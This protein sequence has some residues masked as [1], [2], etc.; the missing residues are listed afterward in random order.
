MANGRAKFQLAIARDLPMHVRVCL[1]TFEIMLSNIR[2]SFWE[3]YDQQNRKCQ[4]EM[5][6]PFIQPCKLQIH[7][8]H[9]HEKLIEDNTDDKL[10]KS[11]H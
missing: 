8:T 7:G 11:Y 6:A 3:I 10:R 9:C 4:K 2:I 1:C 5:L